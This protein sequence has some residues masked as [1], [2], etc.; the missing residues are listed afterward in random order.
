M[1]FLI[2]YIDITAQSL[3][4]S[5]QGHDFHISNV[6]L[7][8]VL[9]TLFSIVPLA[10]H[11]SKK[12]QMNKRTFH[13][14]QIDNTQSSL[15][16]M[17][18]TNSL[19][20]HGSLFSLPN[21]LKQRHNHLRRPT[22]DIVAMSSSKDFREH[23]I[24]PGEQFLQL[25]SQLYCQLTAIITW[26]R[27]R[28]Q[29][30]ALNLRKNCPTWINTHLVLETL[31]ENVS[32]LKDKQGFLHQILH[33]QSKYMGT[34]WQN[35]NCFHP[36]MTRKESSVKWSIIRQRFLPMESQI[37]LILSSPRTFEANNQVCEEGLGKGKCCQQK[38]MQVLLKIL[39]AF[40]I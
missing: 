9:I 19:L 29:T 4:S 24:G 25:S 15:L 13:F 17:S 11:Y 31:P 38:V 10:R 21:W 8:Q 18:T 27:P 12:V 6:G 23:L 37:A 20:H 7:V 26:E 5:N 39:N 36:H 22:K 3:S 33:Q 14:A 34:Q 16:F 28:K 35:K 1:Y 40:N 30:K 32:T 2:L